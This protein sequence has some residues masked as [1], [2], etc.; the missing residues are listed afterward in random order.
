MSYMGMFAVRE[1]TIRVFVGELL[2]I[3]GNIIIGHITCVRLGP[4]HHCNRYSCSVCTLSSDSF[5]A[6]VSATSLCKCYR[7]YSS[8]P[9]HCYSRWFAVFALVSVIPNYW[10]LFAIIEL[11]TSAYVVLIITSRGIYQLDCDTA[12]VAQ[13]NLQYLTCGLS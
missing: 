9:N 12:F 10:T 7:A 4:L 5:N 2:T 6:V 8:K 13:D 11:A 3:D 1:Q